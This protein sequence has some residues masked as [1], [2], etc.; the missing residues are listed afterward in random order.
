[1]TIFIQ[2]DCI[3][4]NK[5]WLKRHRR[6]RLLHINFLILDIKFRGKYIYNNNK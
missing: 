6:P 3:P 4:K 1:M 2:C 5:T